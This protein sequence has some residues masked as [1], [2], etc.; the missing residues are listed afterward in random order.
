MALQTRYMATLYIRYL[1]V[2]D[3]LWHA[4]FDNSSHLWPILDRGLNVNHNILQ[5][6][7]IWKGGRKS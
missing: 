3:S 2:L 6:T 7:D 1:P 5:F 4:W